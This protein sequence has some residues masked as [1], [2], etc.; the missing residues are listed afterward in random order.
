METNEKKFESEVTMRELFRERQSGNLLKLLFLGEGQVFS[1][2]YIDEK[3]RIIGKV[4]KCISEQLIE[5]NI[6][7]DIKEL[8]ERTREGML[9]DGFLG[10]GRS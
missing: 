8:S 4:F 1:I 7:E 9:R 6:P 5:N 10:R 2:K 3:G